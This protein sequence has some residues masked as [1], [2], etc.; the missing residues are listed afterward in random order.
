[1]LRDRAKQLAAVRTFFEERHVLEVDCPLLTQAASID[2]HIDLIEAQVSHGETRYLFSSP[3]YGMKRLLSS[4][5]GDIYQLGHVFRDGE[6]GL[7]HSPEFMMIEWY[8]LGFSFEELIEETLSV[9]ELLLG[10]LPHQIISYRDAFLQHTGI[11]PFRTTVQD[12]QDFLKSRHITCHVDDE[13]VDDY[14]NVTLGCVIEPELGQE[15]LTV[16]I[17]YPPS[18][19]ALSQITTADGLQ[20]AERFEVYR[21]GIEL[22]NGYHELGNADEQRKRLVESNVHRERLGKDALPV[23]ERFLE[24]LETGLPECCGVA[25]GFDRLMMLRHGTSLI[26]DVVPFSWEEA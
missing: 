3:E 7:R 15:G 18:Q 13:A 17:N 24:A 16:L 6:R 21:K 4:G 19:A 14:L 20:V 8:R 22:A 11:D 10:T 26:D 1:M 9:M 5:S 25:V 12:L 2:A 23:D